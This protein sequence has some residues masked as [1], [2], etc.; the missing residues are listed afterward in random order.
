M[1]FAAVLKPR[2]QELA[3][4]LAPGGKFAPQAK[5][6]IEAIEA[7]RRRFGEGQ[8]DLATTDR[9]E[10][11]V[12]EFRRGSGTPTRRQAFILSHALARKLLG[13]SG[14]SLLEDKWCS[15]HLLFFWEQAARDHLMKPA[16]WRGLFHCYMQAEGGQVQRLRTLLESSLPVLEKRYHEPPS[17]LEAASRHRRLVTTDPASHYSDAFL[18]NDTSALEDLRESVDVPPSSWFWPALTSSLLRAVARFNLRDM[19][20][21]MVTLIRFAESIPGARNEVL[22]SCLERWADIARSERCEPLLQFSLDSWGSPQLQ[23][24]Q[25]WALVSSPAKQ[26]VCGWLAQEDLE[27]FYELCKDDG[28]VDERRLEFWLRFKEQMTYTMILLGNDLRFSRSSDVKAFRN[29][30]GERV[31]DLTGGSAAD[32]AILMCIGGWL[33][34]EFSRTGNACYGFPLSEHRVDLGKRQYAMSELKRKQGRHVR[35]THSGPWE[36]SFLAGLRQLRIHPDEGSDAGA[37]Q[38]SSTARRG[39]ARGRTATAEES[40]R[41]P[42]DATQLIAELK[43]LGVMVAD[44][45]V[46]GG[47]VWAREHESSPLADKLRALGMKYKEGRGFYL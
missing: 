15:N 17:W 21:R 13:L 26:M 30:K 41:E 14:K 22:K 34:I 42:L 16:H 8:S 12:E 36:T 11:A 27:D 4:S 43:K 3:A 32:N 38:R 2:L 31:G 47:H 18:R 45:R 5:E 39:G 7:V 10:K 33:F 23:R 40:H 29:R 24:N 46:V 9:V 35:W 44:H 28:G 19:Q 25:L 1:S 20:E 6:L 37:V